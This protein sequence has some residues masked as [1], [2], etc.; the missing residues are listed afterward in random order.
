VIPVEAVP[1]PFAAA[2]AELAAFAWSRDIETAPL[3]APP[4]LAPYA[5]AVIAE[6][7]AGAIRCSGK[8]VLLHDPP[9]HPAWDGDFRCV[10]YATA[11][12]DPE[13]VDDQLRAEAGWSWLLD[14]LAGHG[15]RWRADGGTVTVSTSGHFGDLAGQAATADIE[16][17]AS[18]TPDLPDGV[19]LTAHLAAWQDVIRL[20]A[21]LPPES[22]DIIPLTRA[23][24]R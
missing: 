3:Q 10:T 8:L 14:A 9:G 6:L 7:P 11:A 5:L 22:P 19:G 16:L 18:W 1:G 2:A 15:A 23:P 13:T 12:I 24:R 4:R 17:R 21:G 20:A